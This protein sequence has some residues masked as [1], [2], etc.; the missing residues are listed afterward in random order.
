MVKVFRAVGRYFRQTDLVLVLA[1]ATASVL[2]LFLVLSATH[3]QSR[4][5]LVQIFSIA[6]GIA[7]MVVLS[8]IDY[9]DIAGLWKFLAVA[10]ILLLLAPYVLPHQRNGSADLSWINLGFTTLQPSEFVKIIFVLTFARHFE[11]VK[12]HITSPLNVLLLAL[13]AMIPVG[14]IIAQKDWGMA[15]VFSL[16]FLCM[17]F[18]AGV[19]LRYFV[20]LGI[21]ALAGAPI[22]WKVMGDTQRHR[23]LALFDPEST[24]L[25]DIARQQLSGVSAL[26]SG[27]LFGFG[28]F[29]GPRT[30]GKLSLPERQNDMI[31]AVVGEELG[32]VG[33][34]LVL[35][36]FIVLLYRLLHDARQA[37]DGMGSMICIGIF[38]AFAVQMMINIGMVL[39]LLPVIGISLPF[40]SS[41]GSSMV[42]S[43]MAVGV[44][45]S[46]Y[47]HRKTEI[48][49]GQE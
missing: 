35:L 21:L 38:S 23:I 30:Q 47:M 46:V 31:F 4:V 45:L 3:S 28:L 36:I 8:R 5:F 18:A 6:I 29:H 41:G 17:T 48:F 11:A 43:Y 40:F 39:M 2:G 1:A 37:R 15:L 24:D 13:H 44:A 27:E 12:E 7:L 14:I 9:H 10:G 33:C 32:F 34:V 49:A 16:M 25:I 26:G 42:S 19:Q 20:G 22:L